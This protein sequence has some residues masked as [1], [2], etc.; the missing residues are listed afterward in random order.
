MDDVRR[1]L[2]TCFTAV[3]PELPAREAPDATVDSLASWDSSRHFLLMAVVEE[4]F[5]I[6][7][8]EE[9]VGEIDSFAGLEGHLN[10]NG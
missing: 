7:I 4:E 3:F 6:R 1:R 9:T 2:V 5:G 10:A 8:P